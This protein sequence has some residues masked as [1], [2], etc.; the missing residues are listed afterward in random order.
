MS[1]Y[2]KSTPS[3]WCKFCSRYV[4]DTAIERRNHESSIQHQNNIQRNLR[5]LHRNREREEREQ[6]RAKEEVARLRGEKP[7]PRPSKDSAPPPPAGVSILNPAQQRR[8]HAEQLAALGVALPDELKKEVTGV[9]DFQVV[10]ETQVVGD[11]EASTVTVSRSLA[12][13]LA[14]EKEAEKSGTSNRLA[15]IKRKAEYDEEDEDESLAEGATGGV[16]AKRR[17]AWGSSFKTYSGTEKAGDSKAGDLDLLLNGIGVVKK[18]ANVKGQGEI[19][20]KMENDD[21]RNEA[22]AAE[23]NEVKPEAK[24][25]DSSTTQGVVFK[26]RKHK[27]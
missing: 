9:G 1:E 16:R 26:K 17:Q 22:S 10:N 21:N 23:T 12:D 13:I 15:D 25:E 7:P 11:V 14:E 4:R 27:K 3:Y 20:V 5:D 8:A 19:V 2:W 18:E 6:Q 24:S